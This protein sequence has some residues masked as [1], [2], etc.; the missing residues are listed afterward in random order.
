MRASRSSLSASRLQRNGW[1][2]HASRLERLLHALGAD[3]AFVDDVLGDLAEERAARTI[4]DGARSARLWYLR[5]ALRSM[6]HL[7]GSAMRGA[8]GRRRAMATLCLAAIALAATFAVRAMLN[9]RAPA[10]LFAAGASADGI[11]VNNE[12]PVRLTMRVLDARGRVLPDTGVRYRWLSGAPIPVS[13]RG[14]TTCT[15]AGDAIVRA[16]LGTLATQLVLRCRPVHA[17]RAMWTADLV[18]GDSGVKVPF[19]AVDAQGREVSLLR[20]EISVEDSSVATL[21]VAADGTRIVRPRAPGTTF[22]S[23]Q[24]GDQGRGTSVR[25]FERAR[26]VEG[27]RKGQLLAVPVELAGGE[28]R[29]WQIPAGLESYNLM[30][31]PASDTA[32]VPRLAIVG[33]NCVTDMREGLWCV[34]LHGATVFVYHSRDGDQ[35][36]PERGMLAVWRHTKP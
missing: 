26:T 34:A 3:P 21:D 7:A 32:H 24:I 29:Q 36:R 27:I 16:S 12:K 20:G 13:P 8:N 33:A 30:V 14:V 6:P 15:H 11:V 10:Q 19:L 17:L 18:L 31:L 22:L 2:E 25:V 9:A 28:V 5:E 4:S 35:S 23:L 1:G